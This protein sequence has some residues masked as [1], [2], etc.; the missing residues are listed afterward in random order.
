MKNK[1]NLPSEIPV[2]PLSNFIIFPETTVPLNIFEPRYIQMIDDSMKSHRLIG[3][4][5][6]KKT[7]ALKKP[8]LYNVG[9]LGK[10]TSFNETEDGRYLIVLNGLTR[11][12]ILNEISTV[13]GSQSNV[14]CAN[15]KTI[16]NALEKTLKLRGVEFDRVDM[17]DHQIGLIAQEVEKIIPEV[18]HGDEIKSVTYGNLVGLLIEA[19]K[20]LKKEID[21]LKSSK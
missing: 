4:V 12:Q 8:D 19:I 20:E 10:I 14:V 3:M 2:F 1:I 18:D 7:G 17:E 6:P 5:Q 9:C 11:F 15:I 13:I 21:D 16:D